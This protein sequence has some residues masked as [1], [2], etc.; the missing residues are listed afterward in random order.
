MTDVDQRIHQYA[1]EVYESVVRWRRDF[2]LH[3]ELGNQEVRTSQ[4]VAEHLRAIGVDEVYEHLAGGTGVL[5]V[6]HGAQPGPTVGLRAD[7]DALPIREDTGLP[8]AST[9]TTQ[10]GNQGTV[11]VMHAC[12]HDMH[13]A[14]LM[15]AAQVIVRLRDRLKGKV[16]LVFQPAEEGWS[17]DW[18]GKSGAARFVEEPLYRQNQPDAMFGQHIW[19]YAPRGSVGRLGVL[20]GQ[21]GYC[22]DIVKITVHGQSAHG[23]RPWMGRD[24]IMA[25]AQIIT[26]LQTIPS[27]NTDIYKNSVSVTMGVIKGGTKFNVV[28]DTTEIEG[29]LRFTD[30][31]SRAYMEQRFTDIITHTA[32]AMGCTVDIQMTYVPGL[33]NDPALLE[34]TQRNLDQLFGEGVFTQDP[35]LSFANLDDYSWYTE[36]CPGLFYGLSIAWP[37]DDPHETIPNH[38]PR[39][40]PNEEAMRN[41]VKALA[42]SAI[43][44]ADQ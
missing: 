14:M 40:D 2:H 44:Y 29:A 10:W 43:K 22:M 19:Y 27:K 41:G 23:N 5:G 9:D 21:V 13:T 28:A 31:T 7:M 15:G 34:R 38:N 16:L 39:F 30:R 33:Y 3:P 1:D 8:F 24:S 6:I 32:E 25:A 26:A 36:D 11:P 12:G 18:V 4:I 37:E 17:S 20:P 42:A 35:A